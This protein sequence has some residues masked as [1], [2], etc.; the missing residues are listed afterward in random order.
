MRSKR[1]M[2]RWPQL[3]DGPARA[4]D[5][6]LLPTRNTIDN[7]AAM[8]AQFANGHVCHT[9]SVSRV[10]LPPPLLLLGRSLALVD[11]VVY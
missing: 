4:R 6:Y 7:L 10:I 8:V 5:R 11:P 1:G 9:G 3:R 2:R